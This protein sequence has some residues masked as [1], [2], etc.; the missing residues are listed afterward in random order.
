VKVYGQ[1]V[2]TFG[3]PFVIGL[4]FSKVRTRQLSLITH[5]L[6]VVIHFG[7]RQGHLTFRWGTYA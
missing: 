6:Y 1:W 5:S 7:H 2:Q 3:F 4:T